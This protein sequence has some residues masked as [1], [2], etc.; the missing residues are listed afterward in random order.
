MALGSEHWGCA[1]MGSG[2]GLCMR[3]GLFLAVV[4]GSVFCCGPNSAQAPALVT[5]TAVT[6]TTARTTFEVAISR[7]VTAEVFTLAEPYRVIVDLPDVTFRLPEGTGQAG[8]GLVTAYRYGLYGERK[9]RLVLDTLG[10]VRIERAAMRNA[11][12]GT[13]IILAVDLVA[14]P[15]SSF[16]AGTGASRSDEGARSDQTGAVAPTEKRRGDKPV[17][18]VDPGHGGID[19]GA[20]GASN[21]LEKSVA[22]AVARE[23]RRALEQIGRYQVVMTRNSDVFVSLEQRLQI[24]REHGADLFISLHADALA[25]TG[26][27]KSV[28]GATVYTLSERASDAE[29][30]A[31]AEKENASDLIAGLPSDNDDSDEVRDILFDLMMRETTNFSAAFSRTLVT[32]LRQ[33]IS[34]S[35]DPQRSAAFK[36]LKQAHA[37]SVLVELGYMSNPEDAQLMNTAAWQRRVAETVSSAVDSYFAKRSVT[38][39]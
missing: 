24:S 16:G 11:G 22:L 30:R 27:A 20:V 37:P 17:I 33:S 21:L 9:G 13:G 2:R 5:S 31:M 35:R 18:V 39:Q 34:L 26:A 25:A 28:R 12:S 7:G 38:A 14:T 6:A 3:G 19:P 4:A 15:A 32:K 10:P 23:L 8:G 36:V 29:A 1:L